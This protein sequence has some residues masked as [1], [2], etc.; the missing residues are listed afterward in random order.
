MKQPS[1]EDLLGYVLGALEAQEHRD[2]QQQIDDHPQSA[3]IEEQL[4]EIRASML[5][6]DYADTSGYRPGL[7]RRTCEFVANYQNNPGAFE[8]TNHSLGVS[9]AADVDAAFAND[10]E[11]DQVGLAGRNS[12]GAGLTQR[13]SERMMHPGSWS[14]MDIM[15]C[16]AMFAVIGS[17]LF[18][19]LSYSRYNS[20]IVACQSN[21]QRVG[22]A[23]MC[24]SDCNGGEFIAIPR[25]GNMAVSGSYA[26]ILRSK[27]FI[28]SDDAFTCAGVTR[29]EPFRMPTMTQVSMA[30][31]SQLAV[32]HQKMGG[33]FGHT[34]GYR[35]ESGYCAPRNE[36]L[37]HVVLLAD[38]PST[39][40]PGQIG[41]AHV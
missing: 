26:T 11:L 17:V 13:V 25:E 33:D 7:A 23:M 34:M 40:L 4:L 27:N 36:G 21:M 5:P 10:E 6:L 8:H 9:G 19:A 37:S 3:Q 32:L 18:P 12:G 15:A 14:R 30:T 1:Q 29:D 2:L 39:N 31:G 38:M 35:G 16:V 20:Q 28:E 22:N 24:Y 41:R